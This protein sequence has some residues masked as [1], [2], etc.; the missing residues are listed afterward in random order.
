MSHQEKAIGR[1][2]PPGSPA[3]PHGA[4]DLDASLENESIWSCVEMYS[5]STESGGHL[6]HKNIK[7][8][9]GIEEQ[10]DTDAEGDRIIFCHGTFLEVVQR[11]VTLLMSPASG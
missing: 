11:D 3:V 8:R 5:H 6:L 4:T 2:S 10:V 9:P 1:R 7:C